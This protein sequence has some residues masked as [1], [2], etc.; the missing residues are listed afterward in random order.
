MELYGKRTDKRVLMVRSQSPFCTG[1][2]SF[3][4]FDKLMC[5]KVDVFNWV[6]NISFVVF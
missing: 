6:V 4:A 2:Q 3:D 5:G 1:D